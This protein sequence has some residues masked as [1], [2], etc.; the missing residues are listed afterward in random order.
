M[1]KIALSFLSLAIC[2]GAFAQP[3]G[4]EEGPNVPGMGRRFIPD[5]DPENVIFTKRPDMGYVFGGDTQPQGRS[6]N[7]APTFF[8]YPDTKLDKEGAE[9]F[10]ESL[11][12]K[13]V[14]NNNF[15]TVIVINPT[16]AK[17][18]EKDFDVF[19]TMFN[20]ARS[21]NLKVMGFGNGATFV[22]QVI[23]S[24]AAGHIAGIVS[25]GG[26]PGKT[27]EAA[28]VPAY[29]SGKNAAKAAKP[30]IAA[31][32]AHADEPLLQVVTS[33]LIAPAE[34]FADAWD[35][36][37]SRNFRYNNYKHTHYEGAR[38][39]QYGSYELEPYTDWE[40]LGIKRIVV[41]QP[42][43]FGP[44]GQQGPNVPKQ[45]WYEYWP[46]ELMEGAPEHSVPVM[47]LLHGNANDPRTQ[48]ETSGFLQVAGEERFFV[49]EMEWQGTRNFQ[50]MGQDGVETVIYMLLHKYPQLDPS[51]VYAEG[52]SAGSMTSTALGIKKSHV[53]AAVGGHSGGLFGG[54]GMGPFPGFE[55][56]WNEATQKRGSVETPYC[57]V[58]GTMDTT[59]P[60]MTQDNWKGNSYLN[61]WNAYEQMNGMEVNNNMDFS[62][63]P[64][65]GQKLQDRET[66]VTNK[67]DGIVIETG[68]LYK[69]NVPLIRL[70]AVMDYGHWNFMPTARIMWDF[71]KQYRR[72]PETKRII[73]LDKATMIEK[74][75]PNPENALRAQQFL[76]AA[77]TYELATVEGDQ[78]RVRIFGTAEIFEGKLYIQT[79]KVKNVYKQLIAN[80][81]AE[82][83]AFKDGEWLRIA[84]EL[85]PDERIEAK[86]DML[87]KN[88]D[89]QGMYKVD[90]D[91]T[92]VLYMQNAHAVISSFT[93]EPESFEF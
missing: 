22:N 65:F 48:A 47:V 67:G 11:G 6:F 60:Y 57:S 71:F 92:I 81:K 17:Y 25:V 20:K 4:R 83:I 15:G 44:Q 88:P 43:A 52:L 24:K 32:A 79:G 64:V 42:V 82:I 89:L 16:D 33:A 59:V 35:K 75:T 72:D 63:D 56:I 2:L 61:A 36:V 93:H 34:V 18:A 40:R 70:V 37:L 85:I 29:V 51:R 12:M 21:G 78:P 45:L 87:D 5:P 90:D 26:K 86:K 23:A 54:M 84:C 1:K 14:L 38:F 27:V 68:Q 49:V 3:G 13:D 77:G 30:Y 66:I 8:V 39:G 50:A 41:E 62:I 73:Y 80:P 46:E 7:N 19:V 76:K 69:G 53:F 58:F 31:N 9:A 55:S 10:V 74:T 28:G 91:N